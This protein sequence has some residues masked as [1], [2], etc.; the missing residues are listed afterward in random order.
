MGAPCGSGLLAQFHL[1]TPSTPAG[2]VWA[3]KAPNTIVTP[4]AWSSNSQRILFKAVLRDESKPRL[5]VTGTVASGTQAASVLG[6]GGYTAATF[7]RDALVIAEKDKDGFRVLQV[8]EPRSSRLFRGD[9]TS[10]TSMEFDTSG[11]KLLYV[12][13]RTLFRW[14]D[15]DKQ[16]KRLTN[17]VIDVDWA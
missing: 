17:G 13:D 9:G 6:P 14:N 7:R 3:G 16:P 5:L 12:A 1:P 11:R 8:T 15:G 2:P 10:P 4:L